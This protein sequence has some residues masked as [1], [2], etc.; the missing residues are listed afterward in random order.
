MGVAVG[1]ALLQP[2]SIDYHSVSVPSI[3]PLKLSDAYERYMNDPTHSWS[4]RTREA[5]ET[6]RKLA[7][8]V[9]GA[10]MP[11]NELS[12]VHLRDYIDVLRFLPKNAA[13]RFPNRLAWSKWRLKDGCRISAPPTDG[14]S[15]PQCVFRSIGIN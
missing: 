4:V 1:Q 3:K 14:R 11:L 6:S 13:K 10:D 12:P 9:I 7:V 8:S 2:V 5:Y 15:S